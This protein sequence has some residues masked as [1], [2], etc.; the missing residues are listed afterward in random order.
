MNNRAKI[1]ALLAAIIVA[2]LV[3]LCLFS[4]GQPGGQPAPAISVQSAAA[5]SPSPLKSI[6]S[7]PPWPKTQ[8]MPPVLSPAQIAAL[9]HQPAPSAVPSTL[10][11][12][13]V[14]AIKNNLHRLADAAQAYMMEYDAAG[15]GYFDLVGDSTDDYLKKVDPV[16]SEDYKEI[17]I[18]KGDTEVS[19][20]T[21]DGAT[22]VYDFVYD[23]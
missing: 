6:I 19:V 20:S 11:D 23:F 13:V 3:M 10:P 22:V 7:A 1:A 5:G 12:A 8:I 17:Y 2:V 9:Q 14:K 4:G 21:P 18:K 15:A 16:S